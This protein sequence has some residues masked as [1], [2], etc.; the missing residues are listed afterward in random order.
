TSLCSEC[1]FCVVTKISSLSNTDRS[2][3]AR[4]RECSTEDGLSSYLP[5]P[6]ANFFR[7]ATYYVL[8]RSGL[9]CLRRFLYIRCTPLSNGGTMVAQGEQSAK[10]SSFLPSS[11]LLS[12]WVAG[13]DCRH[14][15]L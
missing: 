6:R 14:L 5:D 7:Y 9:A 2:A 3:V 13:G 12:L 8:I 15:Y 1:V 11:P 10:L 4:H